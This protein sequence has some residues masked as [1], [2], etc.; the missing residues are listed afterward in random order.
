MLFN[1]LKLHK[2]EELFCDTNPV[3]KV[4][5]A[6]R[7]LPR[8]DSKKFS[9]F[10]FTCER[11]Q[12]KT[13]TIN[14]NSRSSRSMSSLKRKRVERPAHEEKIRAA[15]SNTSKQRTHSPPTHKNSAVQEEIQSDDHVEENSPEAPAPLQSEEPVKIGKDFSDLGIIEPLCDAC[16]E[17]KF[18]KATPI[19]AE[20]IPLAL[21]GRDIIGLA[22][23]G[24][25]KTA[26]FALPIL[27]GIYTPAPCRPRQC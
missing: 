12:C 20:A 24:S 26:A 23:T 2:R 22:E 17:L 19:Q 4:V 13:G 10:R 18:T 9:A 25:G 3:P 1:N 11:L 14:G 6:G 15:K 7:R 21:Q 27:Q 16:K 8:N 5:K